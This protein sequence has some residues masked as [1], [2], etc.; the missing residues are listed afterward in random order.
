MKRSRVFA[1]LLVVPLAGS[2]AVPPADELLPHDTLAFV[3]TPDATRLRGA[4]GE[5]PLARLWADDVLRPVRDGFWRRLDEQLRQPLEEELGV[6]FAKLAGLARGQVTLALTQNG[7]SGKPGEAPGVL[8][9]V[10]TR[11][12]AELAAKALAAFQQQWRDAGR[13][14]H[15]ERL[16]GREFIVVT[17]GSNDAPAALKRLLS[18]PGGAREP[19]AEPAAPPAPQTFWL[20]LSDSLLIAGNQSFAVESVLAR[21]GGGGIAL[22]ETPDFVTAQNEFFR[23]ADLFGWVNARRVLGALQTAAERRAA[24]AGEAPDPFA[25]VRPERLL[26]SAGLG[27]VRWAA[28]AVRVTPAGVLSQFRLGAPEA[29]RKGL[30]GL[31]DGELRE[32]LPPPFVPEDAMRFIRW[33]MEGP[34]TWATLTNALNAVTP[35]I[36]STADWILNTAEEAGRVTNPGFDLR[37]QLIGNLGNDLM[38]FQTPPRVAGDGKPSAPPNLL[39]IGAQNSAEM[40]DALKVLLAALAGGPPPQ[41]REFYGRV[42]YTVTPM[43]E[44]QPAPANQRYRALHLGAG[45][46]YVLVANQAGILED[47]LRAGAAPPRPLRELPGF[48]EAMREVVRPGTVFTGYRNRREEQ[49]A[50]FARMKAEGTLPARSEAGDTTPVTE[51]F[52]FAPPEESLLQ[53][54]DTEKLP[55]FAAVEKYFHFTVFAGTADAAGLTLRI[56]APTPPGLK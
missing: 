1:L 44:A 14:L 36:M 10:D 48:A 43:D 13:A 29:E 33:R 5:L 24:V 20:G 32:T 7:W 51:S 19:G 12:Q 45:G 25:T 11:D 38:A 16:R 3:T 41:G 15:T 4:A 18:G 50:A 37:K 2:A 31:F 40:A 30:M 39:L 56:F 6:K 53:W 21:L 46:G 28:F 22:G 9:L 42:I 52:G 17:A 27:R 23:G 26:D 8:L 35:A 54:L 47:H 49:R 34:N 55:P